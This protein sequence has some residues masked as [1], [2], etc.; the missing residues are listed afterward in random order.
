MSFNPI[1]SQ[2]IAV[3]FT[4]QIRTLEKTI[5]NFQK[6]ILE[7]NP[8]HT[9][10]VYAV[11]EY[12]HDLDNSQ[13]ENQKQQYIQKYEQ[14]FQQYTHTHLKKIHWL[15][16]QD[17]DLK[18]HKTQVLQN[19]HISDGWKDYLGNRSGSISEY[20]QLN[21]GIKMIQEYEQQENPQTKYDYFMRT[22]CD[23]MIPNPIT[24]DPLGENNESL[25]KRY[26]AI[27][28]IYPQ[29]NPMA[30]FCYFMESL[31]YPFPFPPNPRFMLDTYPTYQDNY[32]LE[33]YLPEHI[34]DITEVFQP[35][36][37]TH[38]PKGYTI[39]DFPHVET[40]RQN[41]FYISKCPLNKLE[42]KYRLPSEMK[43]L[44]GTKTS[45]KSE[46][47]YWFNSENMYLS[48]VFEIDKKVII[49][50][51]TKL[52]ESSLYEYN[53]SFFHPPASH[54]LFYLCRH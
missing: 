54:L 26:Q 46:Y 30:L 24:F 17:E 16:S 23:I 34:Q 14:I 22:R 18:N 31:K 32:V 43:Y 49:N 7:N 29:A 6:N 21:I 37:E 48:H 41:L 2:T 53:P 28:Q 47:S 51:Y 25:Q 4:G 13:Q 10:H 33:S 39:L 44:K 19:L 50:S 40:H 52:E 36:S 42:Y 27:Q 35:L 11:L 15:S 45:N 38:D 8:N 1:K 9:I 5:H 20:Y 12:P 3:L